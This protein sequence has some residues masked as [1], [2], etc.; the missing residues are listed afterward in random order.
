[1]MEATLLVAT[2]VWRAH[3]SLLAYAHS[4]LK[5]P[6]QASFVGRFSGI[7]N[8]YWRGPLRPSRPS[9]NEAPPKNWGPASLPDH[10]WQEVTIL[11]NRA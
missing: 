8:S 2:G 4:L 6:R 3:V 7:V 9:T 1:M 5:F 11:G 10:H